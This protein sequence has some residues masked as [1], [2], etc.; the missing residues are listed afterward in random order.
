MNKYLITVTENIAPLDPNIYYLFPLKDYTVGYPY[1]FTL[2]QIQKYPH[3]YIYINRLL[4]TSDITNLQAI[5]QKP[6]LTNIQGIVFED[7]G[8]YEIIKDYPL[9]KILYATHACCSTN[10]INT[11]LKY[12][13]SVI[14]S[15]DIT[16][17]ETLEILNNSSK[18]LIIYGLGHLP[19]MY[20]RRLLNTNYQT[21]FN[22]PLNNQIIL[23]ENIT[24]QEFI[25]VENEY[26]TVIYD[27][28]LYIANEFPFNSK[29]KYIFLNPNLTNFRV[30]QT[31]NCF[32]Y[33][34]NDI[35]KGFLTKKTTYQLK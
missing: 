28:K 32:L 8:V 10:T 1:T 6:L 16:K 24:K 15:P 11:Y 13:D 3:A 20:S 9:E 17:E 18:P 33:E 7:L 35:T 2:K 29:I 5:L 30:N 22:Y 27:K 23:K 26:G 19:Y 4:N 14:I 12:M 21:N 34:K 25:A 31:I